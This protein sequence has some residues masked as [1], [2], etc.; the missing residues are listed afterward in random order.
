MGVSQKRPGSW[1]IKRLQV[2]KKNQISQGFVVVVVVFCFLWLYLKHIE[3][4]RL[5]VELEQQLLA[6][7]TA[8]AMPDQSCV[9]DIHHSS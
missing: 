2:I 6:Y 7:A 4:P 8:T 3:V 9:C 1:N 5:G